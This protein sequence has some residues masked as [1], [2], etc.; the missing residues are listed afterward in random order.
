MPCERVPSITARL[1]YAAAYSG[2]C[3]CARR[4]LSA[5][6]CSLDRTVIA[7]R[8]YLFCERRHRGR[9]GQARQSVLENLT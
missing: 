7:R 4:S 3:S 8:A 1:A 2:V 5:S 9:L 6:Y